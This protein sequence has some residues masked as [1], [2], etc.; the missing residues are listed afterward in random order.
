MITKQIIC[1]VVMILSVLIV[2]SQFAAAM[3]RGMVDTY[4]ELLI[5]LADKF[6]VGKK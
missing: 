5:R 2:F 4:A 1:G 6:A 3:Y